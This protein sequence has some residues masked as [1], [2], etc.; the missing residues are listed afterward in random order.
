M[1]KIL[2]CF[3]ILCTMQTFTI[4]PPAARIGV[5][6]PRAAYDPRSDISIHNSGT[7]TKAD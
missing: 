6:D 1:K 7:T 2:V 5:E 4:Y 3:S